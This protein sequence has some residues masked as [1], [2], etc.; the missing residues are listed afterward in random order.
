MGYKK[1]GWFAQILL[2]L[3]DATRRRWNWILTGS[4]HD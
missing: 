4:W 3:Q 2:V 1:L